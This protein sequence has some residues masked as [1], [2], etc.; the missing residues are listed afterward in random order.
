MKQIKVIFFAS[1][2]S[3]IS[4]PGY[5]QNEEGICT[6]N[7]E[8]FQPGEKVRY[9]LTYNW[10]LA[11]TDVGEVTFEVMND[12]IFGQEAY[13]LQGKGKTYRFYD[14]FYQVRDTYESWVDPSTLQ[15]LYYK[16]DVNN[17]GYKIDIKYRYNWKDSLAYMESEK[18]RKPFSRDTLKIPQCTN[19]VMSLIYYARNIDFSQYDINEKIPLNLLLD[20][21]LEKVYIRYKGKEVKK[22]RKLGKFKCIKFTGYLVK[23]DIFDGGEDLEVWVTDDENRIPVWIE[24][25]IKVGKIKA[26]L[27]EHEGLKYD[28]KSKVD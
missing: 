14:W 23:G 26:R 28:I 2:F 17:D 11:W 8:V 12:N 4:F 16:R 18:T 5:S 21:E 3:F 1:I 19:D 9:V 7:K 10:F 6:N 22:V 15:P 13:H 20:T 24:S 27:I 25:P